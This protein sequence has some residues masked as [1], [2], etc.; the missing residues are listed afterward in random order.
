[1]DQFC[2]YAREIT[3]SGR[4]S[5]RIYRQRSNGKE[6]S[7]QSSTPSRN[8][9]F[10]LPSTAFPRFPS[11]VGISTENIADKSILPLPDTEY[12]EKPDS[13]IG[14]PLSRRFSF[15]VRKQSVARLRHVLSLPVPTQYTRED[16]K[17]DASEKSVAYY[18]SPVIR[19]AQRRL[20]E[21][22]ALMDDVG[23]G[24]SF[25]IALRQGNR[26]AYRSKPS[27]ITSSLSQFRAT[28]SGPFL[29]CKVLYGAPK[30][31]CFPWSYV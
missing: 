16:A 21:L 23:V 31:C 24:T 9:S 28:C 27:P 30:F 4:I 13:V 10:S 12:M 19:R 17:T 6:E 7:T 8:L 20:G 29:L 5:S 26:S 15:M 3:V 18:S 11:F 14:S 1:M 25:G 2:D 22:W